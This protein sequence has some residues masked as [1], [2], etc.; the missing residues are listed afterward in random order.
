MTGTV[1][2]TDVS[3][4]PEWVEQRAA[5]VAA[6]FQEG[7]DLWEKVTQDCEDFVDAWIG[8]PIAL[9]VSYGLAFE[10]VAGECDCEDSALSQFKNEVYERAKEILADDYEIYLD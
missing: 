10:A 9:M 6:D 1:M 8:R 2:G 5:N 7:D 4:V 3:E